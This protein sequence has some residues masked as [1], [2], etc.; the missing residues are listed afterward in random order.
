MGIHRAEQSIEIAASPEACF[1]AIVDYET[2]PS[3]QSA[4]KSVDVRSRDAE[5]C[6]EL[7][8]FQVDAKL[9]EVGYTL[10]Y[11]YDAPNR[12]VLGDFVEG[13][14]VEQVEGEYRF[15]PAGRRH[16]RRPTGSGSIP[17]CPS[18]ASSSAGSTAK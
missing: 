18:P 2:F 8:A 13:D 1:E 5:G 15:E 4:V 6:G 10:R 16:A 9:R 14:G 12:G 7:V 17:G 3:W 11:S